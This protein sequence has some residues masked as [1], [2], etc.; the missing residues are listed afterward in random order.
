MEGF[1]GD[2]VTQVLQLT[3]FAKTRVSFG[4]RLTSGYVPEGI[5]T[6]VVD[7]TAPVPSAASTL[8]VSVEVVVPRGARVEYG[9]IGATHAASGEGPT[10]LEVPFSGEAGPEWPESLAAGLDEVRIGIPREYASAVL[11]SL[12]SALPG[13]LPPGLLR[14]SEGAHGAAGS[15]RRLFA[16]LARAVVELL[17]L[18]GPAPDALVAERLRALG[19]G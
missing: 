6:S 2:T 5:L 16:V 18:G 10:R 19:L 13:R 8:A 11:E 14:I 7:V 15:S 4:N 9:L 12:S 3:S 1:L 17:T